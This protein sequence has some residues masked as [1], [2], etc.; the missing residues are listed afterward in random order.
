MVLFCILGELSCGRTIDLT[1]AN[2][3]T[4]RASSSI[5]KAELPKVDDL[6]PTPMSAT[7]EDLYEIN[8][9]IFIQFELEEQASTSRDEPHV[10]AARSSTTT[11]IND[12]LILVLF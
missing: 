1:W 2:P 6:L 5:T 7:V 4:C 11:S 3:E 8:R 10:H 12:A 9:K